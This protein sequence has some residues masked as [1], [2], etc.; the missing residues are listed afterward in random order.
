MSQP[1]T[2]M[3]RPGDDRA[4]RVRHG[5]DEAPVPDAQSTVDVF[6]SEACPA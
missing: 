1:P 4:G 6:S 5:V 3:T 2:W